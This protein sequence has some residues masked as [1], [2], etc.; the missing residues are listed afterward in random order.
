MTL[1]PV[2]APLGSPGEVAAGRTWTFTTGQPAV[3][4][5][6][7]IAFISDRAGVGNVWLMNPDGSSPRQLTAELAPVAGFDVTADGAQVAW[8]AGGQVKVDA[9]RRDGG[10]NA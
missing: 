4:G 7:Q 6:N 9:D 8:S 1:E 10:A 3:S 2:V 5:H